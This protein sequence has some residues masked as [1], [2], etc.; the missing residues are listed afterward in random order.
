MNLYRARDAV[1]INIMQQ[2][3][4]SGEL[5]SRLFHLSIAATAKRTPHSVVLFMD[6]NQINGGGGE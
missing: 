2:Y 3:L 6:S 1:R 4:F 5:V